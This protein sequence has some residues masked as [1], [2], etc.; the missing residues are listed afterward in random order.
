MVW[1]GDG[2]MHRRRLRRGMREGRAWR[3]CGIRISRGTLR[4]VY[5][6]W[7]VLSGGRG[8]CG[9]E[10]YF[11]RF[12][13][14]WVEG[15][16]FWRIGC[17]RCEVELCSAHRCA[18][19]DFYFGYRI[20]EWRSCSLLQSSA[21]WNRDARVTTIKEPSLP[22]FHYSPP[23][24]LDDPI[25]GRLAAADPV[26]SGIRHMRMVATTKPYQSV[27]NTAQV[28]W[29]SLPSPLLNGQR[30]KFSTS[31]DRLEKNSCSV[32]KPPIHVVH[33]IP[34]RTLSHP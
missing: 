10:I 11:L 7:C 32:G 16:G 5:T 28:P 20:W 22:L 8:G 14:V 18:E 31:L 27:I 19:W 25:Q 34:S 24:L 15:C 6:T 13:A 17:G 3:I 26:S 23:F 30:P 29:Q 1:D 2:G 33:S 12:E 21:T 9:L 4:T